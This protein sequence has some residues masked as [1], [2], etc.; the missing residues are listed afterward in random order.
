MK[1]EISEKIYDDIKKYCTSNNIDD[2]EKFINKII[3]QGFTTEKWGTIGGDKNVKPQIVEKII[4]SAVTSEPEIKIVEKIIISAV[5]SEE[6][7]IVSTGE[8]INYVYNIYVKPDE[9]KKNNSNSDL[10]G[11]NN[12]R[13]I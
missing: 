6:T 12:I 8:S 1:V 5:T 9:I 13:K 2:I 3:N 11:E 4:I 10:Y 7:K